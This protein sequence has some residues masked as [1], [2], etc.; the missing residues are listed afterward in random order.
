MVI[1]RHWNAVDRAALAMVVLLGLAAVLVQL[2]VYAAG[3]G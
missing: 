2:A 3:T 1:M